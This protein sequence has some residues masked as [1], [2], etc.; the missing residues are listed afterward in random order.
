[1]VTRSLR[2]DRRA[3]NLDMYVEPAFGVE[4]A[5]LALDVAVVLALVIL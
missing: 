3:G 4:L 2:R 1:M 5:L